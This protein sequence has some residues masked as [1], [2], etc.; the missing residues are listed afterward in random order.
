MNPGNA[1]IPT[2]CWQVWHAAATGY[3]ELLS[4]LLHVVILSGSNAAVHCRLVRI[5]R[6]ACRR[7]Q[8][9]HLSSE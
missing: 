4:L 7:M 1:L 3:M 6:L 5:I 9:L 2:E 8:K